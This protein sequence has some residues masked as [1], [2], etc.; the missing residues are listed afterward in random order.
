MWVYYLGIA[1]T[2]KNK[3]EEANKYFDKA[4][5]LD[6]YYP[7]VLVL[8]SNIEFILGINLW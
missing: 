2:E 7:Y 1:L 8:K 5:A 4:L 3:K 6:P